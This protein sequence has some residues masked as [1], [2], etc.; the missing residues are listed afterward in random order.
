MGS[1]RIKH[2]ACIL[3]MTSNQISAL[4][5]TPRRVFVTGAGG[6]TGQ[7]LFR[8]LLARDDFEPVGAVRTEAS[9]E[10]LIKSGVPAD[11]IVVA[12]VTNAVSVRKACKGC[13]AFCIATSAKP[14][15]SGDTTKDGKP[16]FCFPNGQPEQVDWIGQKNQIDAAKDENENMHVVICSSMGGT[17]PG[18]RLNAFGRETLPD[19]SSRGGDILLWKRK[20]E[21]YL[22]D[23][24]L[25]YTIVHP[26][27]LINEPGNERELVLGIDDSQDGTESRSVP[28]ED[29]A[30]VMM[31]SLL[32]SETYKNRSFDLRSKPVGEGDVTKDFVALEKKWLDGKNCNYSLGKIA[33][34]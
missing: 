30:E 24:G 1:K 25:P 13:V 8:K 15:P 20:A 21:K 12:D 16:I 4:A 27:G 5:I 19:G 28:R 6:Q 29:V 11:S 10:A 7:A 23:S 32:H 22:I 33:D 31:Q 17:D 14:A 9:K 2:I 34:E 26:G 3:L 18:N